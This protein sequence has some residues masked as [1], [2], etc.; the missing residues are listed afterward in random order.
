MTIKLDNLKL[1][2]SSLRTDV[3]KNVAESEF[4]L[5]WRLPSTNELIK[6]K[7]ARV[8]HAWS[9]R[10]G[11]A[12][13]N[14]A[15]TGGLRPG[16]SVRGYGWVW[17]VP[18]AFNNF[19]NHCAEWRKL[20]V[21]WFRLLDDGTIVFVSF[22][23]QWI[24][25][26]LLGRGSNLPRAQ[27]PRQLNWIQ[28]RW[29]IWILL[30]QLV[31][32]N[33][34]DMRIENSNKLDDKRSV[35]CLRHRGSLTLLHAGSYRPQIYHGSQ[36]CCTFSGVIL[37]PIRLRSLGAH[38][39]SNPLRCGTIEVNCGL[40]LGHGTCSRQKQH[41]NHREFDKLRCWVFNFYLQLL[42]TD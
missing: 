12:D 35:Y 5:W 21:L 22:R 18:V 32:S 3:A 9:W 1:S 28:S 10:S 16:E 41:C 2:L 14:W 6:Y 38:Y 31:Y 39:G 29:I 34:L 15:N 7:L 4:W 30:E 40:R 20:H 23:R 36:L 42:F 37:D 24:V 25:H 19:L 13:Y 33:G 26:S 17:S 27:Q 8:S 11:H